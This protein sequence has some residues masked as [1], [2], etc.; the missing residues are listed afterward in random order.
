SQ[1]LPS[2]LLELEE[3]G[4][5]GHEANGLGVAEEVH[6][7]LGNNHE[8]VTAFAEAENE[9]EAV[10]GGSHGSRLMR[11]YSVCS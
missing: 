4:G 5:T 3:L 2:H 10:H 7:E 11:C 1:R 6:E 8:G 9:E